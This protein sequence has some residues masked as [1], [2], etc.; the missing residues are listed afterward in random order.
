MVWLVVG[1]LVFL[2]V[3]STRVFA[4]GWRSST[5]ARVG[6]GPWK[7]V[8]SVVSIAAFVLLVWGYGQARQQVPLWFPPPFTRHVTALLMVPVF[9]LFLAAY[10]PHNGIKARLHHPQLLSVKLWA[11]AHLVANGNLA[12]VLLFGGLLV[13]A[14]LAYRAARQRDAAS[15]KVYPPGKASMTVV[16]VVAGLVLYGV[17]VMGLHVWLFGVRP[18]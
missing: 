7:G 18:F 11:L 15:G 4:D 16:T 13:W 10:V 2:G 14:I 3:H 8:Y 17:F 1:L 5:I 12:D 9:V 6:E